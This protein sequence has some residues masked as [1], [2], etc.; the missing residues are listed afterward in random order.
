MKE[1]F[2]CTVNSEFTLLAVRARIR[3]TLVI[4]KNIS[5]KRDGVVTIEEFFNPVAE[6]LNLEKFEQC[7]LFPDS[8]L[9]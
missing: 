1:L 4:L 7:K 2:K 3:M 6:S 9:Q 8:S 5:S